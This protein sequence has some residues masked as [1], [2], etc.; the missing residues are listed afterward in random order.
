MCVPGLI[1][2]GSAIQPAR[3]PFVL[4]R[5]PAAIVLRLPKCVRSGPTC[6]P[7]VS[8]ANGVTKNA[9]ALQ[10][11]FLTA[12]GFLVRGFDGRLQLMLQPSVEVVR[13]FG[14]NPERHV[15]MLEAAEFR[16]LATILAGA[17]RLEP[18][19]GGMTGNQVALALETWGPET[20]NDIVGS[21]TYRDGPSG[22]NVE[23]I[24]G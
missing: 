24:G 20:M 8:A 3:F 9:A 16:T 15:S 14:D 23:F 13:R 5:V 10:K 1:F 7:R 22:R 4:E 21:S 2:C 12:S 6:A 18:L 17:V 11:Y 19:Q